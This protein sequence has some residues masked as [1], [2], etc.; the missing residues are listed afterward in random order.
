MLVEIRWTRLSPAHALWDHCFCLYAYVD[1]A[2]SEILY[3]GKADL[4][5][6]RARLR[7]RHKQDVFDFCS[8]DLGVR[9][10]DFLHGDVI[11]E[12]GSRRSSELLHDLEGLLI[13]RLRPRANIASTKSRS[14]WRPRMRVECTGAWPDR[15]RSFRDTRS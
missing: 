4:Q 2:S 14:A 3:I 5:T 1:C 9:R 15:R 7:G 12:E 8:S 11:V 6:V 13:K 10:F